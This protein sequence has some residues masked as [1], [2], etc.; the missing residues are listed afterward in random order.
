M[1][2][3]D[4]GKHHVPAKPHVEELHSLFSASKHHTGIKWH[5]LEQ[6]VTND[7]LFKTYETFYQSGSQSWRIQ[8]YGRVLIVADAFL[9][10]VV[11]SG[12]G[13]SLT[14]LAEILAGNGFDVT[15]LYVPGSHV[16]AATTE[17]WQQYYGTRGIHFVP[18]PVSP[19]PYDSPEDVQVSH[20]IFMWLRDQQEFDVIHFA[21][22][23]VGL[24]SEES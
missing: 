9:G 4:Q 16:E 17:F 13:T 12:L 3:H 8:K 20:R 2:L 14:T 5:S 19:V 10:A 15:M 7:K 22:N 24:R 1:E 11:S 6:F 18:L 21:D 23:K